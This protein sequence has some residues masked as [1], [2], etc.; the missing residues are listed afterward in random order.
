MSNDVDFRAL[1]DGMMEYYSM[2]LSMIW[3]RTESE[4]V[5]GEEKLP[6][7]PIGRWKTAQSVRWSEMALS[8][9]MT[10]AKVAIAPTIVT[11]EVSGN[12]EV[13]DVDVKHWSGI[14]AMLFTQIKALFPVLWDS[15]RIHR[16][17]SGGFH[18]LYRCTEPI[19]EGNQ[20]LAF[21]LGSKKAGIETRGEGGYILCPPGAGYTVYQDRP[22]PVISRAERDALITICRL[23][24]QKIKTVSVRKEKAHDSVYDENPFDHYNSSVEAENLLT[25]YGWTEFIDND[26]FR[27]YTRPD[28]GKG[29]SASWIKDKRLYHI[30]TSST[31]LDN[32]KNYSPSYVLGMLEYNGDFKQTFKHLTDKGFGK[33]KKYYEEKKIK[34]YALTKA[35]LPANFSVESKQKLQEVIAKQDADYP[36]GTYWDYN[37]ESD[38]YSVSLTKIFMVANNLGIAR[39]QKRLVINEGVYFRNI[40][41][42]ETLSILSKYIKEPLEDFIKINDA[43]LAKWKQYAEFFAGR[44]ELQEILKKDVLRTAETIFYKPFLNGVVEI[45]KEDFRFVEDV[46]TF[47]KLIDRD[48]VIQYNFEKISEERYRKTKYVRFLEL[49]ISS[50]RKYVQKCIGYLCYDWKTR[51]KGYLITLLEG[52]AKGKGGGSGK[53]MF[54]EMLGDPLSS[55]V[56]NGLRKWTTVMS[57]SGGQMEKGE[58]EMLQMWNG[59]RIVHF[60][61]IP[62]N[63]NLSKLKDVVTDGG[64]VKKLYKDVQAIAAEDYPNIGLSGQWGINS[65]D[66]PGV[67]RRVRILTFTDYFNVDKEVRDEFGGSF[68]DIWSGEDWLGYFNYIADGVKVLLEAGGKLEEVEESVLLWE[69]KFDHSFGMGRAELRQWIQDMVVSKWSST[70]HLRSSELQTAY[71]KFCDENNIKKDMNIPRLHE[72]IEV[73]CKRYGY[74]YEHGILKRV[75]GERIRVSVVTRTK[76]AAFDD[77]GRPAAVEENQNPWDE[78]DPPF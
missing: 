8:D 75:D 36:H 52:V 45:T 50:D 23:F 10:K 58:A 46:D 44:K 9:M 66:D 30:F 72:A 32:D 5:N 61:D 16:T 59:E 35:P 62:K 63:L 26:Q 4:F 13:I 76:N 29:I 38:S 34:A 67:K 42:S 55:V 77:E 33:V 17:T 6:K 39:Y 27:H 78:S 28:K 47:K 41:E 56:D 64:P 65:D 70:E 69:K 43:L 54:F 40:D 11:G 2:G 73:W 68:P 37:D 7:T 31:Q 74:E 48:T 51:G 21:Q 53:G 49:A 18:L 19:K 1:W 22:I 60:S 25:N 15:I 24:D 71:Q 14:D 3:S 57:I 20:G 12:L